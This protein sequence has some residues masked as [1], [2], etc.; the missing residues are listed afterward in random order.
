MN[1][2]TDQLR[3]QGLRLARRFESGQHVQVETAQGV[4]TVWATDDIK[5]ADC[6]ACVLAPP[7]PN[8]LRE[9]LIAPEC[10]VHNHL[11]Y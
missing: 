5:L 1:S 2:I 4:E 7:T 9:Y 6:G 10:A 11:P 8:G 3:E